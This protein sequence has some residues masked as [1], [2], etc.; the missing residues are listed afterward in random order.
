MK[1][2]AIVDKNQCNFDRLDQL[3]PPL[4]YVNHTDEDRRRL[5]AD[6]NNYIWSV[7]EPHVKFVQVDT[8]DHEQFLS[9][10]CQNLTGSFPG[11]ELDKDFFY[12]TEGSYSFPKRYMEFIHCQPTWD[13][14]KLSQ[15]ENMNHL[16]CLFSLK[17]NVIENTCAIISNR[18]DLSASQFTVIDSITKEDIIR[19]I[20]R[21]YF[22]TA[23][24]IKDDAFVK[25][26]YQNPRY[27]ISKIYGLEDEKDNIQKLSFNLLKY[28]LLYYFQYDPS[29]YVNK[30]ATR[31]NG[32]YQLYGD[33]LMLHE[34]EE[35]IFSNISL[36]EAKRLNV[37]A[38]GR[39]YDREL[40]N[41]EIHVQ[42]TIELDDDGKPIEK[43]KTPLWSRYIVINRRMIQ[44]QNKK[45]K[46]VNCSKEMINTI[47]CNV[48][49]RAKYCSPDCHQEHSSYHKDDCLSH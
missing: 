41:E 46:C 17:H 21:R 12:H 9:V 14:Y 4:L 13:G 18:Y 45:N 47:T 33:V 24:L 20:R 35:N 2:I 37:L 48:C 7:I 19:V 27:L 1:T 26:Y 23:V 30:I 36:H 6:I 34:M 32:L 3:V 10:I 42:P 43:K 31:I 5:K 44:W 28:N 38:Y 11:R 8:Q 15:P 39:L 25:Y 40:K 49:Y 29:K 22:F 16:A